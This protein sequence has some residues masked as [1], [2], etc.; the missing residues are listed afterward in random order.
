MLNSWAAHQKYNGE[1]TKERF[2][3]KAGR[4]DMDQRAWNLWYT[5]GKFLQQL[6]FRA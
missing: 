3:R 1:I 5:A 2:S 4:A 6:Y